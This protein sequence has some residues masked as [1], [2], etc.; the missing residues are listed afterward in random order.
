MSILEIFKNIKIFG[1]KAYISYFILVF[2][3]NIQIDQ[4]LQFIECAS[5]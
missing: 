2:D 4:I 1:Q 5:N 3:G